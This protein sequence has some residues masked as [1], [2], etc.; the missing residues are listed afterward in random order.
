MRVVAAWVAIL[1]IL[2]IAALAS[3][4][5]DERERRRGKNKERITRGF[6]SPEA[7]HRALEAAN[8]T[9]KP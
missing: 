5:W 4:L 9:P 3:Q 6:D 8:R 2:G 1:C 7:K